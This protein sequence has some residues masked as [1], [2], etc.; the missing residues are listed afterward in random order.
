[1]A[2]PSSYSIRLGWA[3]RIHIFN[4]FPGDWRWCYWSIL[5]RVPC[6]YQGTTS[7]TLSSCSVP[8]HSQSPRTRSA[9][10]SSFTSEQEHTPGSTSPPWASTL[11]PKT[12]F[13]LCNYRCPSLK[14]VWREVFRRNALVAWGS[15]VGPETR[16]TFPILIISWSILLH[17]Y[18]FTWWLSSI[19]F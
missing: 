18:L 3:L 12:L 13:V 16:N 17:I 6:G 7:C 14:L 4:T 1:M 15:A 5:E 8:S 2:V 11:L 9:L 19:D 10:K